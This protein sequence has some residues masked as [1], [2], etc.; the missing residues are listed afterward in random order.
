VLLTEDESRH[1][2]AFP[3]HYVIHPS[4]PFWRDPSEEPDADELPPGFRYSSE[5]NDLWLDA[6]QI[7]QMSELIA[8]ID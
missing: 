4:F 8:V 6:E 2:R 5:T 1:A 3:D 7:R